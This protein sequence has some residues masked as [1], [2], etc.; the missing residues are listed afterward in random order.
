MSRYH[1]IFASI[2]EWLKSTLPD[3]VEIL[4][5]PT[6]LKEQFKETYQDWDE[7]DNAEGWID[8]FLSV[9]NWTL[10]Q[11][12]LP[13]EGDDF[14]SAEDAKEWME[15]AREEWG[16]EFDWDHRKI[17]IIAVNYRGEMRVIDGIHR[18]AM[19]WAAA[20]NTIMAWVGK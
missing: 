2:D 18:L 11:I 17:P 9:S 16:Y 7:I 14:T 5:L 10:K 12:P 15:G 8:I 3:E 13:T 6:Q 20:D 4:N 1:R 19:A